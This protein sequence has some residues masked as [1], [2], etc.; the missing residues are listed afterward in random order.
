MSGFAKLVV[1]ITGFALAS[2]AMVHAA[3][4]D[5]SR[6]G[7]TKAIMPVSVRILR[8]TATSSRKPASFVEFSKLPENRGINGRLLERKY[9]A[10]RGGQHLGGTRFE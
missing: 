5:L 3:E 4:R 8:A 9:E 7:V 1:L 6:I 2:A 10:Y